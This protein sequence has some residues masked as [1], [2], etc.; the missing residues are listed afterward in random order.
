[1]YSWSRGTFRL[2]K[3]SD[4]LL[5][6]R[7]KFAESMLTRRSQEHPGHCT[8]ARS[9]HRYGSARYGLV[10]RPCPKI[11]L[12]QPYIGAPERGNPPP[13]IPRSSWRQRTHN[14]A[15][16]FSRFELTTGRDG[17]RLGVACAENPTALTRREAPVRYFC[18]ANARDAPQGF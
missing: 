1:M 8:R 14:P 12:S 2:V 4:S 17:T 10:R 9:G 7:E 6:G 13:G 18:S 15:P 16:K 3:D 5:R 11:R